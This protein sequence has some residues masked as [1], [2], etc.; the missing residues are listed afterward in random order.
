MLGSW[1]VLTS[2]YE[3]TP[4]GLPRGVA[5]PDFT[6]AGKPESYE[7]GRAE[8][9]CN[10]KGPIRSYPYQVNDDLLAHFKKVGTLIEEEDER[11]SNRKKCLVLHKI[12]NCAIFE[13]TAE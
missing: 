8:C 9:K 1:G 5:W 2:K 7:N 12:A 4:D 10:F 3:T 11:T 6:H 13:V